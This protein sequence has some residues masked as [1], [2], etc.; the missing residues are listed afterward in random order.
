MKTPFVMINL[1]SALYW[2]DEALQMALEQRGF[3]RQSRA[4]SL[5]MMNIALGETRPTRI[6]RNLGVTRQAASQL[7]AQM[8]RLGVI[9]VVPDPSDRRAR[10]VG[11][12]AASADIRD[13][14]L[15]ILADLEIVLGERIGADEL[16]CLRKA[17]AMDWGPAP[18]MKP[19]RES[20]ARPQRTVAEIRDAAA[21]LR[22]DLEAALGGRAGADELGGLRKVL[23]MDWGLPPAKEAATESK[24]SG[25]RSLA[26]VAPAKRK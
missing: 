9:E 25:S 4:H 18:V 24:R 6:A 13:A 5:V 23:A 14:A 8:E 1:L 10:I 20:K 19:D 3:V 12:S 17:L 26:K 21:E 2:F 11:F 16:D 15:E 22:L 7:L